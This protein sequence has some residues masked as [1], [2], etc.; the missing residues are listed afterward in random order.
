MM[1][2]VYSPTSSF[3]LRARVRLAAMT[4]RLELEIVLHHFTG[5]KV[6]DKGKHAS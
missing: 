4:N 5:L 3:A 1:T 2:R 6:D